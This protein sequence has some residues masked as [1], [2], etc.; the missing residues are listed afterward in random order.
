MT[1]HIQEN[2]ILVTIVTLPSVVLDMIG[3]V[4]EN[5]SKLKMGVN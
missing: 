4:C 1:T 2:N 3:V 5:R